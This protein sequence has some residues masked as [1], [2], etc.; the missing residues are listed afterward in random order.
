[1][2]TNV[3]PMYL[4]DMCT[5]LC[6]IIFIIEWEIIIIDILGASREREA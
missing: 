6:Y 4:P 5:T 3:Q 2:T 1:M